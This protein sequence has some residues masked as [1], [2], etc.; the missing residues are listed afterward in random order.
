MLLREAGG[1]HSHERWH[2]AYLVQPW[3]EGFQSSL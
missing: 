2:Q 3:L 1:G